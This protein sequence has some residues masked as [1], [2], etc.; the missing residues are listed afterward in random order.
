MT[1][2]VPDRTKTGRSTHAI[3]PD[4]NKSR[5]GTLKISDLGYEKLKEFNARIKGKLG[6]PSAFFEVSKLASTVCLQTR[7]ATEG[8]GALLNIVK[9]KLLVVELP[10]DTKPSI[11]NQLRTG[12]VRS[13][14]SEFAKALDSILEGKNATNDNYWFTGRNR[15]NLCLPRG[16]GDLAT[17]D[18]ISHTDECLNPPSPTQV[19]GSITGLPALAQDLSDEWSYPVD[20][21]LASRLLEDIG[22]TVIPSDD[23]GSTLLWGKCDSMNFRAPM[24]RIEDT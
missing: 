22:A 5:I 9:T 13:S 8:I 15:D 11:P 20:N 7:S 12:M 21:E 3:F 4:E 17:E 23:A 19:S 10:K 2:A 16:I 1:T 24:F 18:K 6:K 14:A